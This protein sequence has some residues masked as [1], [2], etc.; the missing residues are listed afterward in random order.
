MGRQREGAYFGGLWGCTAVGMS[1]WVV[2]LRICGAYRVVAQAAGPK[3]SMRMLLGPGARSGNDT[4]PQA[5]DRCTLHIARRTRHARMP[6][7][8]S[9]D[10]LDT[11]K[12]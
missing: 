11:G 9:D 12:G 6:S 5:A 10:A 2:S 8:G 1:E 4:H 7:S 3:S